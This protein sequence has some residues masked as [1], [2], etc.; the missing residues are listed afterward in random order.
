MSLTRY[1]ERAIKKLN[2]SVHT[3]STVPD[4]DQT[5][6][7][8]GV[9]L[10]DEWVAGLEKLRTYKC[11]TIGYAIDVHLDRHRLQQRLLF[12]QYVDHV[13]VAQPDYLKTFESAGHPSVHWLPVGCEPETH[14]VADQVRD[15]DV[16]FVGKLGKPR[17]ERFEILSRILTKN[18]TNDTGRYYRPSEMG[19]VYSRSKIVFNKS[20]RND[21]NMRFF[22]GLAAGALVITDRIENG[23]GCLGEDCRYYVV[24]DS[25]DE[26]DELVRYYLEHET[27]RREIAARGQ[28]WALERHTYVNRIQQLVDLIVS[29]EHFQAPVRHASDAQERIW[30]SQHMRLTGAEPAH[31][32]PLL[33]AGKYQPLVWINLVVAVA[34]HYRRLLKSNLRKLNGKLR[35]R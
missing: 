32:H 14:F 18:H 27:E 13:F 6:H 11:P 17:T 4:P 25:P 5:E 12:S 9:I 35:R 10:M 24:Y 30:R 33:R 8:D 1:V 21:L 16:G 15:L 31:A 29:G 34:D 28:Q 20:V 2:H 23:M 19:K 26:A 3:F 22:E 7:L